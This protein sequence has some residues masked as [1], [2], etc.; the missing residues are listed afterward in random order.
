MQRE[1]RL[2]LVIHQQGHRNVIQAVFKILQAIVVGGFAT[3]LE[4]KNFGLQTEFI[5]NFEIGTTAQHQT[6]FIE[7]AQP[8]A[9]YLR[10]AGPDNNRVADLGR[11]IK[12]E[13]EETQER[14]NQK[15]FFHSIILKENL[16]KTLLQNINLNFGL[17]LRRKLMPETEL[18]ELLTIAV[19]TLLQTNTQKLFG[20][21]Y[22]HDVSETKLRQALLADDSRQI[23]ENV[24]RLV[25]EREKQKLEIRRRYQS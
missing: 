14:K 15:H 21:L 13:Q 6:G 24:A 9:V 23:A 25:I 7:T 16:D 22:R 4:P 12:T 5:G 3:F 20:I 11:S 10:R 18:L 1:T 8:I 19:A 2:Y 17:K